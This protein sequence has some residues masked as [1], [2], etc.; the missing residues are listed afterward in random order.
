MRIILILLGA[1][2]LAYLIA[3]GIRQLMVERRQL[4]DQT[5]QPRPGNRDEH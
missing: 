4:K 5:R 1:A 2:V 3:K